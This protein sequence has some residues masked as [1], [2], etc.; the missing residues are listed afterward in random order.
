MVVRRVGRLISYRQICELDRWPVSEPGFCLISSAL[1]ADAPGSVFFLSHHWLS[2]DHPDPNGEKLGV[3]KQYYADLVA[4]R[5]EFGSLTPAQIDRKRQLKLLDQRRLVILMPSRHFNDYPSQRFGWDW[6]DGGT[7]E[8]RHNFLHWLLESV[9]AVLEGYWWI[10]SFALPALPHRR[11]CPSCQR[12]F[13][14]LL[15]SIPG[16]IGDATCFLLNRNSDNVDRGWMQLEAC[17][18][19]ASASLIQ[20]LQDSIWDVQL[21]QNRL[22]RGRYR[23][24]DPAD[25]WYLPRMY[26]LQRIFADLQAVGEQLRSPNSL[27]PAIYGEIEQAMGLSAEGFEEAGF[28]FMGEIERVLRVLV[29]PRCFDLWRNHGMFVPAIGQLV[30][31]SMMCC[32]SAILLSECV[33]RGLSLPMDVNPE[34]AVLAAIYQCVCREHMPLKNAV[35]AICC[36]WQKMTGIQLI[37]A[38]PVLGTRHDSVEHIYEHFQQGALLPIVGDDFKCLMEPTPM[39]DLGSLA[40]DRVL[41]SMMGDSEKKRYCHLLELWY[42]QGDPLPG[43]AAGKRPAVKEL[44]AP[45]Y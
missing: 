7:P 18:A 32:V 41:V 1:P 27:I 30:S 38:P 5:Q 36:H 42:T 24:W 31:R 21:L 34:T 33:K 39:L 45:Q 11:T 22:I 29:S 19:S 14:T 13:P 15:R 4:M 40:N 35:G 23:C 2:P 12:D 3:L 17:V 37:D 6:A 44:E 43:Q 25:A 10:D 16:M 26:A 28:G 20:E 8:A 9:D